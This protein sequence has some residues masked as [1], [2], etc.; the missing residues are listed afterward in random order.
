MIPCAF[1]CAMKR[2]ALLPASRNTTPKRWW[3]GVFRG[4]CRDRRS[5]PPARRA[6][7][8]LAAVA[9]VEGLAPRL[10]PLELRRAARTGRRRSGRRARSSS[11]RRPRCT[12]R[13]APTGTCRRLVPLSRRY[14]ARSR[15]RS[16]R[17]VSAPPSPH[18]TFFV[19]WKLNAP[20]A[21]KVP[22]GR[23]SKVAPSGLGRVL[24]DRDAARRRRRALACRRSCPRS[25]PTTTAFVR[26]VRSRVTSAGSRLPFAVHVGEDRA[27]AAE[28]EG[29]RGGDERVRGDDELV[30]PRQISSSAAISRACVQDVTRSVGWPSRFASSC[31]QCLPNG[32]AAGHVS[33]ER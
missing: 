16:S 29:V 25:G 1:M 24:D 21:P 2:V 11:R 7:R 26:G 17:M 32:S 30:T 6:E 4:W 20:H 8:E 14:S 9:M 22:S 28:R 31:S 5:R 15:S 23:P 27:R 18:P 19:S 10:D 13:P 3:L 33:R 12:C